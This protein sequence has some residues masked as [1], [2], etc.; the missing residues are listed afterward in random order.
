MCRRKLVGVALLG[1]VPAVATVP[2]WGMA[3]ARPVVEF[4]I[5]FYDRGNRSPLAPWQ[6]RYYN[7]NGVHLRVMPVAQRLWIVDRDIL[8]VLG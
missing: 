6:G 5:H 1:F 3:L 8:Q 2:L 7:F 4:A